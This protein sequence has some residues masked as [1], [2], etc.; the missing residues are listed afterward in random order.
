MSSNRCCFNCGSPDHYKRKCPSRAPQGMLGP[1]P[2]GSGSPTGAPMGPKQFEKFFTCPITHEIMKDPVI[3]K[4]GQTYER[5]AIKKWLVENDTSPITRQRISDR[6]VNNN[7]IR[8]MMS[9]LGYKLID[10]NSLTAEKVLR[11]LRSRKTRC[12]KFTQ[13]IIEFTIKDAETNV[14]SLSNLAYIQWKHFGNVDK[15]IEL[16]LKAIELGSVVS[17]N[18]LAS[19]Y[20]NCSNFEK[21][22]ELYKKAVDLKSRRAM[23]N[24][25]DLYRDRAEQLDEMADCADNNPLDPESSDS[26]DS[27]DSEDSDDSDDSEETSY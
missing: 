14:L 24:L 5:S 18:D 22:E 21:A 17:L 25:A 2:C 8:S 19:I 27:E 20:T 6:L 4:D 13:K 9:E 15:A 16:C 7:S 1:A 26:E 11:T 12:I 3:A 23:T 10:C